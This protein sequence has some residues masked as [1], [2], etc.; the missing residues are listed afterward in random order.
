[1]TAGR[2][3]YAGRRAVEAI[4][5]LEKTLASHK[6]RINQLEQQLRKESGTLDAVDAEIMLNEDR[7]SYARVKESIR[8]RRAK[9]G[10]GQRIAL[11]KLKDDIFLQMK[12]NAR[13][14]K[15]QLRER[16]RQ[17][18]FE[19]DRFERTYRNSLNG[20]SYLCV[21]LWTEVT[22]RQNGN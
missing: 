7:A 19:L 14:V 10:V 4:L 11:Q 16:L 6:R 8:C 17:R 13:A 5:L 18:K 20:V 3:Q 2:S 22:T 21:C 15:T 1:M 9:L 12:V